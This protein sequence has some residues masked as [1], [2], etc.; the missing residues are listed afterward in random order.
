MQRQTLMSNLP[1]VTEYCDNK[2][3]LTPLVKTTRDLLLNSVW[4]FLFHQYAFPNQFRFLHCARAHLHCIRITFICHTQSTR[5]FRLTFCGKT[6][7][8]Q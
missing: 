8:A 5:P 2:D 4:I 6:R 3:L 1:F 7:T